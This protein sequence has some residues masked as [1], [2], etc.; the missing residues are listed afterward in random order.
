L[1]IEVGHSNIDKLIFAMNQMPTL[2]ENENI[3]PIAKRII[4]LPFEAEISKP[5]A[6]IEELFQ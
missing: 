6:G 3:I 2:A 1:E 5:D 4:V